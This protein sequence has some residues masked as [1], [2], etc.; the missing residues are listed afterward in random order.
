MA[1]EQQRF[2]KWS[3]YRYY[4]KIPEPSKYHIKQEININF[5]KKFC[6]KP[7]PIKYV[8]NIKN[9]PNNNV[10]GGEIPLQT[11]KQSRFTYHI[12]TEIMMLY[13]EV[14]FQIK[15]CKYYANS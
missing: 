1:L 9:T 3:I 14:Y 4:Y 10:S 15:V 6:F 7:V 2:T 11:L 8:E 12:L 5:K 13:S